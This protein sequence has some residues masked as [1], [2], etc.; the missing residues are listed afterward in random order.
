M[1]AISAA[2][3]SYM[4]V[5]IYMSANSK[6]PPFSNQ[7]HLSFC[8]MEWS[9]SCPLCFG[10]KGTSKP[11]RQTRQ[12]TQHNNELIGTLLNLV[13]RVVKLLPIMLG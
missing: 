1:M 9:H 6:N 2:L 13:D 7:D 5:C 3:Q 12:C 11:I 8:T 4:E 10:L